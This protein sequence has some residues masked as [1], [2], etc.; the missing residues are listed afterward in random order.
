MEPR[1]MDK[2]VEV[3]ATNPDNQGITPAT[4]TLE[5]KNNS[6]LYSD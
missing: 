1:N 6:K 4:S 5:R 2:Q 3:L